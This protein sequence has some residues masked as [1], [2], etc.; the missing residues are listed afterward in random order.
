MKYVFAIA[1]LACVLICT[2]TVYNLITQTSKASENTTD[3]P[4]PIFKSLDIDMTGKV[5]LAFFTVGVA[6]ALGKLYQFLKKQNT[7]YN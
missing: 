1:I 5:V 2:I 7:K 3:F 4:N 6:W